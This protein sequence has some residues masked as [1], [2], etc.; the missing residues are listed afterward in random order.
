MKMK[1]TTVFIL[2]V[3]LLKCNVTG[4]TQSLITNNSNYVIIG[5][6]SIQSNASRFVNSVKQQDL[7]A[8]FT[9]NPDRDLYY[10]YVLQ[11][12][13]ITEAMVQA[14]KLRT[15]TSFIDTWVYKGLLGEKSSGQNETASN[16]VV[17]QKLAVV[18][19]NDQPKVEE[20]APIVS[21][22]NPSK[23]VSQ[24]D[25]ALEKDKV[26]VKAGDSEP[27]SKGFIFKI[28]TSNGEK[29]KGDIDLID[30]DRI[31][32]VSSYEANKQVFI[33]PVNK[34][35]KIVLI[36]NIFG[37][38]KV[39]KALNYNLPDSTSGV[40]IENGNAVVSFEL[41]KLEKGDISVMYNVYF[42]KD[43]AIMRQDSRFEVMML[44]NMMMENPKYI[45]KLHGHTN[46]NSA[47]K[48]IRMG[49]SKNFFSISGSTDGFGTAKE[50]SE[51][52]AEVIRDFL[53]SEGIDAN[54][55]LVKGWGGKKAL[56]DKSSNK[57]QENVRVEVEIIEDK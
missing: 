41:I 10:V 51:S 7:R 9:F 23:D 1:L 13:D 43:A 6:F 8:E 54:R 55:L 18:K 12:K 33:K 44:K 2:L 29:L 25:V 15:E 24:N 35:G 20:S 37:Y 27:G 28:T 32:K 36:C 47:G 42:F 40:G 16:T 38:R 39:Q 14:A 31:I 45:I 19:E 5:A 46:G 21:T 26:I 22:D 11:T 3:F 4:W 50:L 34:T 30:A 49:E 53:M 17:E 56:H 48:I 57:A 52:R